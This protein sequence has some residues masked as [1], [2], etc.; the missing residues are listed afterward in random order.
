MAKL[1]P[2]IKRGEYYLELAVL[3]RERASTMKLQESRDALDAMATDYERLADFAEESNLPR[4]HGARSA[5]AVHSRRRQLSGM[6]F[7]YGPA[8]SGNSIR[9]SQDSS[10]MPTQPVLPES[11]LRARVLQ[12][13]GDAR[14]PLALPT[15]IDAGYGEGVRC[16]LCDQ[17]ITSDK[18]EYDV[19]DPRSAKRLHLHFACHSAWQR[20]CAL[21]L[22]DRRH[23]RD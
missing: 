10:Q 23:P 15:R 6:Q 14:L 21:R 4:R 11:E 19:T 12:R 13:I 16:D 2:R 22:G 3:L 5:R 9:R 8:F 17:P 20:E 7:D 18:I 1:H